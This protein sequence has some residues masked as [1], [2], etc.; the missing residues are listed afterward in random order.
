MGPCLLLHNTRN[1][2]YVYLI[3]SPLWDV[4]KLHYLLDQSSD[5][6]SV[7]YSNRSL[8]CTEH[9][10][11]AVLGLVFTFVVKHS[12]GITLGVH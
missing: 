4:I 8:L 2:V 10:V 6:L 7:L 9:C 11:P 1:L 12:L 5:E 3:M